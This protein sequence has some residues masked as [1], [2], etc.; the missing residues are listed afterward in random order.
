MSGLPS[1]HAAHPA[2]AR[3]R[4]RASTGRGFTLLEIMIVMG[5]ILILTSLVLGVG[6]ALLK[7][8]LIHI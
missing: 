2:P 5:V 8:S 1:L 4:G 6:S 7:L 3:A